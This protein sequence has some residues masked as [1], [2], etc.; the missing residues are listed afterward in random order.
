MNRTGTSKSA[1]V[2]SK[3]DHPVIDADGHIVEVTP[4]YIDYIREIGGRDIAEQYRKPRDRK[5]YSPHHRGLSVTSVHERRDSWIPM[6]GW[7]APHSTA[8]RATAMAPKLLNKRLEELGMDF[9][10][11][12]P[13]QGLGAAAIQDDELRRVSCRA[14]NAYAADLTRDFP[15]TMVPV[16]TIPMNTPEEAIEELDHAVKVLGFKAAVFQGSIRRPIESFKRE[17][18]HLADMVA[19]LELFGLDSDYDYDIVWKKCVELKIP[20]GFHS[21]VQGMGTDSI[22]NYS[23]NHIGLLAQSHSALCKA[24]FLGGV[25]KRFPNMRFAFL[26]GGVSWACSIYADLIGHWQKRGASALS[27]LDPNNIDRQQMLQLLTEYGD[28]R[29]R[30]KTGELRQFFDKAAALPDTM[31]DYAASG[32]DRVEDIRD[33]FIPHFYFGCEADDPMSSTAYN[34]SVNPLGAAIRTI[35]GSDIG[36]WDV[37]VMNEVVAEAYELVES[38]AITEEDF[39]DFTFVNPVRLHASMNPDFFKGTSVETEAKKLIQVG[40]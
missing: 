38:Y 10:I 19:R 36:H 28:D 11:L 32:I 16:A 39:R 26:E 6:G 23:F 21:M 35:F 7:G 37:P 8:D 31:D 25:T 13:S 15:Q 1:A 40:L 27:G 20:A 9:V 17:H 3:L 22:T 30:A 34:Q 29:V 33:R 4:I 14:Y 5:Y 24:L 12:Y 2:R 18:P